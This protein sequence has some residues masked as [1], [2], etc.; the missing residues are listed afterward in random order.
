M[1]YFVH[2][3]GFFVVTVWACI[4]INF[5]LPRIMPGNAAID[6]MARFKGRISQ[7]TYKAM[8][9]ALGTDHQVNAFSAYWH[10]LGDL[11]TGHLGTSISFF[12]EPVVSVVSA[13]LPWTIGLVGVTTVLA[14]VLGTFIGMLSAW[15]RG[16]RLDSL[17]PPIFIVTSAFPYF[18]IALLALLLFSIKLRWLPTAFGYDP[19]AQI[20]MTWSFIADV[21]DHAILP[22]LTILVTSVGGWILTMRNNMITTLSEDYVRM[23][24]AKGLSPA[25][26]MLDYAGRNAILPN[27]TGFAMSLGFV[28][29]G[30][31]LV[32]YVFSYPGVGYMLLVAIENGD[33]SLMQALFLL[34]TL[35]VLVAVVVVDFVTVL[36]DP[37]TRTQ[38]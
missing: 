13:A 25:R 27:L 24:R 5:V 20:A 16:G 1:R 37:R 32:E 7:G 28:V 34:I 2:R 6:M 35:C 15:R 4:T 31:V 33:Y 11:F 38:S 23:A 10:Y 30:A 21:L 36:A 19:D 22:A 18:F 12:P 17:L 3:L 8:A 29:G 14:F 26:I 9:L